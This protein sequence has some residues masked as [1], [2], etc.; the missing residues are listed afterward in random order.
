V[1][2]P[3]EKSTFLGWAGGINSSDINQ[4]ITVRGTMTL[5]LEYRNLCLVN[6]GFTD[7]ESRPVSPQSVR[8]GDGGQTLSLGSSPIWLYSGDYQVAQ[9]KWMGVALENSNITFTV[10][11]P[12][13]IPIM[14]PISDEHVVV[15]DVYGFPVQGAQVRL[16][17]DNITQ[18]RVTNGSGVATFTQLPNGAVRGEIQYLGFS[19]YFSEEGSSHTVYS[20]A[21]LSYPLLATIG[22][23]ATLA[24]LAIVRSVRRKRESA[25]PYFFS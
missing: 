24:T 9:A 15:R 19:Q 3:E 5:T 2:T 20:T 10:T 21:P 23:L 1:T 13:T 8:I 6:L 17:V 25:G 11:R 7:S 18:E 16:V 12:G 4:T 22:V 14:L